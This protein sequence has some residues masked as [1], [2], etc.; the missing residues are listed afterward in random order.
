VQILYCIVLYFIVHPLEGLHITFKK[1]N[2]MR[3]DYSAVVRYKTKLVITVTQQ[4]RRLAAQMS[5]C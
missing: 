3:A 5:P 2:I 4:L 1:Y